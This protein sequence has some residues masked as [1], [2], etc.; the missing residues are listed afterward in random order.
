MYNKWTFYPGHILCDTYAEHAQGAVIE[1][2]NEFIK[3]QFKVFGNVYYWS[4]LHLYQLN[5]F[6]YFDVGEMAIR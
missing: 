4:D 2:N 5:M 6:K 1:N 3:L